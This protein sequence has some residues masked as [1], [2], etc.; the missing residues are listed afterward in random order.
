MHD[1]YRHL[2]DVWHVVLGYDNNYRT[3]EDA[4]RSTS[5]GI[6]LSYQARPQVNIR[7]GGSDPP[8][9]EFLTKLDDLAPNRAITSDSFYLMY[10]VN[11]QGDNYHKDSGVPVGYVDGS[12]HFIEGRNDLILLSQT[13]NGN[14]IYW[15]DTT[16]DG[17][18]DPPSLL[19]LLDSFGED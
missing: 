16:G 10:S 11:S 5:G 12:I 8:F 4:A 19:G 15:R 1:R 13:Q 2:H 17:H 14:N 6:Q 18:P 7:L 3:L 9:D